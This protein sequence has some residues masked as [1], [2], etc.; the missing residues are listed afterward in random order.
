MLNKK[1]VL[2]VSIF[3]FTLALSAIGAFFYIEA[4]IQKPLEN[5]GFY[6]NF[7]IFSGESA[8]EVGE[9]LAREGLIGDLFIFKYYLWK[10]RLKSS[11]KA[12]EYNLSSAMNIPAIIDIITKGKIVEQEVTVFIPEGLTGAEIE[13]I[14]IE[15]G[16]VEKDQFHNAVQ[17]KSLKRYYRYA[18]LQDKPENADLEGYIFPDTYKFYK[19]TTPEDILEKMLGNFDKKLDPEMRAEIARQNRSVFEVLTMASIIQEEGRNF[20][21][22]KV[23]SG[24]FQNRLAIGKPLEADSTINFITGKKMSQALYSDLEISS[25]YNT[26][27][28]AG[29]PP[30]PI[31][32]PGLDAI[33]AAIWPEKNSYLYFLH[34]S[35]GKA[36]YGKTYEDH[37]RNR[38]KYLN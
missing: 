20:E 22:M 13:K 25:P 18:F 9:K 34:T 3:L 23:V 4:Q 35:E 17:G 37:L 19:K 15:K 2:I 36:V 5:V 14:L 16:L 1:I 26:Y 33:K 10:T 7:E 12:G 24:I 29:L 8:K 31:D 11:I 32:N 28:N 6:R 38:A 30:G 27:K 21:D